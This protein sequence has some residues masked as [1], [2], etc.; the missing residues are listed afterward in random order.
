[1]DFDG[2]SHKPTRPPLQLFLAFAKN[3]L[4]TNILLSCLSIVFLI[5]SSAIRNKIL[6]GFKIDIIKFRI[7]MASYIIQELLSLIF[8][9]LSLSPRYRS[10]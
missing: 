4:Y 8:G 9:T 1:M 7:L 5:F 10:T 3:S 2:R 6:A